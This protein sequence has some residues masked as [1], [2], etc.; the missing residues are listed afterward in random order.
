MTTLTTQTLHT[1]AAQRLATLRQRATNYLD[2][3]HQQPARALCFSRLIDRLV[4]DAS[5]LQYLAAVCAEADPFGPCAEAI[6]ADLRR[7]TETLIGHAM[8]ARMV[9]VYG[10]STHLPAAQPAP[11][12]A[13]QE[14]RA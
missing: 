8:E 11:Q 14:A 9:S 4:E 13:P 6:D 7:T 10:R 1:F 12:P 2:L 5:G 3:A